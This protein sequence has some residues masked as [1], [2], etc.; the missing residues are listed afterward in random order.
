MEILDWYLSKCTDVA[1]LMILTIVK[2]F[3]EAKQNGITPV[4]VDCVKDLC[5]HNSPVE[6]IDPAGMKV[7]ENILSMLQIENGNPSYEFW[8]YVA[9]HQRVGANAFA[10]GTIESGAGS[11]LAGFFANANHHCVEFNAAVADRVE[12]LKDIE[13][14]GEVIN[15]Y[16]SDTVKG[17]ERESLLLSYN[18]KCECSICGPSSIDYDVRISS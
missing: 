7:Y 4:E 11:A 5:V 8:H 2:V 17:T 10:N 6:F 9:V 13:K 14:G 1:S 15:C 18:I 16:I 3:A 12:I